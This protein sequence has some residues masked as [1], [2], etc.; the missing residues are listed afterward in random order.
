MPND[1]DNF[2]ADLALPIPGQTQLT[3]PATGPNSGPNSG[4]GNDTAK[5]GGPTHEQDLARLESARVL[6]EALL[7]GPGRYSTA[8]LSAL[9]GI[10]TECI[11]RF[12][13]VSGL[14]LTEADAALFTDEDAR[15]ITE[16]YRLSEREEFADRTFKSL[17]RSVGHTTE[18]LA[19]WQ[20]EALVEHMA[21]RHDLDDTSARLQVLARI[22]ELAPVFEE[23]LLHSWRRQMAALAARWSVEFSG[24]R[25]DNETG[26]GLL[27]LP[28]AVGFADIVSFTSQTAKM[29]SSE[30]SDFVSDFETAARDVITA[31]GGRVVKTIGDAVLYIADDV[32]TGAQVALGLSAAGRSQDTTEVP[33]VR[34]SLVWGRVLS[35]FGDVFGASVNL[36]A[37]LSDEAEPGTVLLDPA[38]AALLAGDQRYAL[39]AQ[40][41]REI[42]G[43]GGI[44]PV[45]LQRAYTPK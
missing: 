13:Q 21:M 12:W 31:N 27:P 9:T 28:R 16:F 26:E 39:T 15:V 24:A 7:G 34:V 6:D 2:S 10:S 43:L 32:F 4:P 44:A 36:A 42:Q 14:P 25:A 41:E 5:L 22:Q 20:A 38:T 30:L 29:R 35:R 45:R 11:Q 40:R 18:R 17:V 3:A 23:Q 19:L 37:R 33:E 8:E 1:P